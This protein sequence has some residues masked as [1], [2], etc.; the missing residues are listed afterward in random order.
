M[1]NTKY[2]PFDG[3]T[4]ENLC[5]MIF[6]RKYEQ[7]S[8]QRMPTSPGD[9]GL[10]GFTLVSGVGFQCYCPNK[11]YDRKE[12]YEKQRDKITTDLKK[13]KEYTEEI[14]CRLGRTKL[15][16]WIFVTPEF[17]KNELIKHARA[18]EE[19]VRSWELPILSDDFTILLY[20]A[21]D[22]ALEIREFQKALGEVLFFSQVQ[23]LAELD[24]PTEVYEENIDRKNKLRLKEFESSETYEKRLAKLNEMTI[25]QFLECDPYLKAIDNESPTFYLKLLR[26]ITEFENTV[27]EETL[28]WFGNPNDLTDK[29]KKLLNERI[30][31]DLSPNSNMTMAEEISRRVFARWLAVCELDYDC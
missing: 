3:T 18:K 13:L 1:F 8:Y 20:D 15:S 28:T 16:K 5:Q 19:E 23:P 27:K 26:V 11:H 30:I 17:D 7:E 22:Y 31:N 21:D 10:E 14:A 12:L 6:K 24:K 4:W 25:K 29:L 9:F 2:G